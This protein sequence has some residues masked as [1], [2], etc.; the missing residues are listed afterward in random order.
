MG[1]FNIIGLGVLVAS[2]QQN[3]HRTPP[4]SEIN[5]IPRTVIDSQFRD[6]LPYSLHIS[7]ISG[8]QALKSDLNSRSRPEVTKFVKPLSEGLGFAYFGHKI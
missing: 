6:A 7:G 2:C 5:S 1:N 3:N 8:G 4:L